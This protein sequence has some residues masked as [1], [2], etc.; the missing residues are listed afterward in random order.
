[1]RRDILG[2]LGVGHLPITVGAV[3][4]YHNVVETAVEALDGSGIPVAAVSTGFP[5]GQTPFETKL[6]ET[7]A[8][9]AAG[10]QEIDIAISRA[11]VLYRRLCRAV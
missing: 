3:C 10:A 2:A 9:L 8:S 11:P 1:V 4:V 6:G 5:A 7:R